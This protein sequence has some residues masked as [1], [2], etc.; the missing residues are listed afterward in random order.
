V[1]I[2]VTLLPILSALL[3]TYSPFV[4]MAERIGHDAFNGFAHDLAE[5]LAKFNEDDDGSLVPPMTY[6]V[7]LI[8]TRS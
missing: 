5:L 8:A 7:A 3:P 6:I 2:V 1:F 4:R